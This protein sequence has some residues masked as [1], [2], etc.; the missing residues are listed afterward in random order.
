MYTVISMK[1][2]LVLGR[3]GTNERD[4][5]DAC[6]DANT[7]AH[8][9]IGH[10]FSA[11]SGPDLV[12]IY[13]AQP[14]ITPVKRFADRAVAE[15]R[16][17]EALDP[18]RV[19]PT[20]AQVASEDSALK[21]LLTPAPAPAPEELK[22]AAAEKKAKKKKAPANGT[23]KAPRA[24]VNNEGS[25]TLTAAGKKDD[26][27]FQKDSPRSKIFAFVKAAEKGTMTVDALIKKAASFAERNQVLGAL[28]KLKASG[29][30]TID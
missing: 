16:V 14:G 28:S 3:F 15:R 21:R 22:A 30:V 9:I 11:L 2:F 5:A 23:P 12:A 25:V 29:Y 7:P 1:T 13:N 18:G 24:K 20:A 17:R 19:P 6:Q 27:R 26:I 8:T 10:D 4:A